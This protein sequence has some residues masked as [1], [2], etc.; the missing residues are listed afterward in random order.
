[1]DNV[2]ADRLLRC[3]TCGYTA[4]KAGFVQMQLPKEAYLRCPA[5]GWRDIGKVEEGKAPT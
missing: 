2:S 1:M 3:A 5:C 4:S